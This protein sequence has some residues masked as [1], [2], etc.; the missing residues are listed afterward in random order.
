MRCA[1]ARHQ[2]LQ[3]RLRRSLVRRC[4]GALVKDPAERV[5]RCAKQILEGLGHVEENEAEMEQAS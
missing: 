4:H 5:I 3:L 1:W 2:R